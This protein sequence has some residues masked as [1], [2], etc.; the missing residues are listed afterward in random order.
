LA[1][2]KLIKKLLQREYYEVSERENAGKIDLHG[3]KIE[4]TRLEMT[5]RIEYIVSL[6]L[7]K[8]DIEQSSRSDCLLYLQFKKQ[9]RRPRHAHSNK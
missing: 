8:P 1:A 3:K 2:S 6:R 4:K 5:T 7:T 9:K